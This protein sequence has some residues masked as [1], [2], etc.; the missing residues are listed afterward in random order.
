MKPI[1][2]CFLL[3]LL[4]SITLNATTIPLNQKKGTWQNQIKK[5]IN[6]TSFQRVNFDFDKVPPKWL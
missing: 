2:T 4:I 1:K 3:T 5:Q 6:F